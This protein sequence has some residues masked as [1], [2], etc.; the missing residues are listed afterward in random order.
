MAKQHNQ[1]ST[2]RRYCLLPLIL[3]MQNGGCRREPPSR[4]RPGE[5]VPID[6]AGL[7][8][9]Q[10][11]QDVMDRPRTPVMRVHSVVAIVTPDPEQLTDLIGFSRAF[12]RRAVALDAW[13]PRASISGM[14]VR[15]SFGLTGSALFSVIK[16]QLSRPGKIELF[17]Q[18]RCSPPPLDTEIGR[19]SCRERVWR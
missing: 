13:S 11:R 14:R 15:M 3:L 1:P 10:A 6:P 8:R 19:A 5:I 17:A 9:L 18:V 4:F 7:A 2:R 12:E 16:E